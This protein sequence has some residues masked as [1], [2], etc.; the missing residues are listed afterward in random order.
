MVALSAGEKAAISLAPRTPSPT[1][2]TAPTMPCTMD[3]PRTWP[4]MRR[5][6]Q[7]SALSVPNSRTRR[8]TAD[9]VSRLATANEAI[10]AA[11]ASHLPRRSASVDALESEPLTWLARSEDVVTVALG[12]I[13]SISAWTAA[14]SSALSAFT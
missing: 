10:R 4:T 7:P 8:E 11:M 14:M 2:I 5:P 1:P 9:T 12:M 6:F 3:S 13:F